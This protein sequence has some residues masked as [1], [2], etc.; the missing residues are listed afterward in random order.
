V[1]PSL[2]PTAR[3]LKKCLAFIASLLTIDTVVA[4]FRYLDRLKKQAVVPGSGGMQGED[5][6]GGVMSAFW[7]TTSD[8]AEFDRPDVVDPHV[9]RL[10]HDFLLLEDETGNEEEGLG[11]LDSGGGKQEDSRPAFSHTVIT[12]YFGRDVEGVGMDGS[13]LLIRTLP[14]AV[15]EGPPR[16]FSPFQTSKGPNEAFDF[17]DDGDDAS[18]FST[19]STTSSRANSMRQ[20]RKGTFWDNMY[21]QQWRWRRRLLR[22][23]DASDWREKNL[24]W[25]IVALLELPLIVMRNVTIPTVEEES[26]GRVT[27]S[28]YP[29]FAPLFLMYVSGGLSAKIGSCPTWVAVE[30][31]GIVVGVFVY[32]TTHENKPPSS[33]AYSMTLIV[34]AFVM[35][36]MWIYAIASELVA[37]IEAMGTLW[38]MPPSLLGL[39]L[40]AWG[41]SV[42]DLITNI[43][44]AK[45]GLSDMAVAGCFAGPTFNLLVG[46]GLSFLWKCVKG[47]PHEFSLQLDQRS[48][49]SLLFLYL[50]LIANLAVGYWGGWSLGKPIAI[51]LFVLYAICTATQIL[52]LTAG[53][54]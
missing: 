28:M 33:Y 35:C 22:E 13:A 27:A 45:A 44:V 54:A 49:V 41:N 38:G 34:M 7:F 42:G 26:W 4:S 18:R 17:A 23:F 50:A 30:L 19:A 47:E 43:A 52:M 39:T 2:C 29:V 9:S 21:W 8:L 32:F 31:V 25:K 15:A 3:A 12:E 36:S 16:T 1:S 48:F 53:I 37:V 40:L 20:S 46:M 14:P 24:P 10:T 5:D 51:T 6:G 11:L